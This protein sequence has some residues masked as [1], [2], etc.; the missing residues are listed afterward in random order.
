MSVIPKTIGLIAHAG[1]EGAAPL[2]R[3]ITEELRS[4]KASFLMEKM[5]A[6]LIGEPSSWDEISLSWEGM[7]AFCG[8][9]IVQEDEFDRSLE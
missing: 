9:C 7:A 2:V 3:V 1:K 8:L 6:S 4:R 5:T